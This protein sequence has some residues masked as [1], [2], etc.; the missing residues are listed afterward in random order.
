M[1]AT[2]LDEVQ[3]TGK[4]SPPTETVRGDNRAVVSR[5]DRP[6]IFDGSPG[7]N[8]SPEDLA[9]GAQDEEV[10]VF[11]ATPAQRRFWLLDQL[12][13]GGNPALNMPL[14][15]RLTGRLDRAALAESFQNILRRHEVL[16]TTF[17]FERG[18]LC[19]VIAPESTMH[20]DLVD[21]RDFPEPERARVPEH[22]ISEEARLPF[23][24]ARGP[25]FRA[26]LVR[27]APEEHL[28]LLTL[29]H[30][31][32]DGWT[33]GLILR[34]LGVFYTAAVTRRPAP[35]PEL[36]IQFAEFALWQHDALAAGKLDPQIA[37][38]REQLAGELSPLDLPVDRPR[39]ARRDNAPGAIRSRLL[40]AETVQA[41]KAV[42]VREGVSQFMIFLAGF[43]ALLHRCTGG[44]EDI[45]IGSPSANRDRV[46]VENLAGLFVNPLLLRTNLSGDPTF[47]ELLGRVRKTVLGAFSHAEVP[48][49][50]IIEVIQPRHLQVNFLYQTA[51]PQAA[52]LPD[53]TLTPLASASGG[54]LFE[55]TAAAVEE[56]GGT[57]LEIEYNTD[58]FEPETIDGFLAQYAALLAGAAA[59]IETAVSCLPLLDAKAAE[60]ALQGARAI[61]LAW[62]R[63]PTETVRWLERFCVRSPE[64]AAEVGQASPASTGGGLPDICRP[65]PGI[66]LL[67]LDQ[68]LHPV[69]P[70]ALG[71]IF[72]QGVPE[73][74][75]SLAY[76]EYVPD[77]RQPGAWLYQ[78]GDLGRPCSDG[79]IRWN[80]RAV[81]LRRVR[82]FRT[83]P[84]VTVA[85]LREHPHIR[86]AVVGW[87]GEGKPRL[88]AYLR[89]DGA[90]AALFAPSQLRAFLQERLSDEAVPVSFMVLERFPLNLEGRL[91]RS[92]LPVPPLALAQ[93]AEERHDAPYLTIHYQLIDLW[94]QLLGVPAVGIRDDFF[95]L[96]GNSLLAMRMLYRIEQIFGKAILPVALFKH[97][98]IEHLAN[99]MLKNEAGQR[100][101]AV[102]KINDQGAKTPIFYLHGDF[103]GG[104]F[105]SVKLSRHLGPEQPFYALPPVD[106]TD[107]STPATIEEMAA[108]QV[109]SIRGVRAHGPYVIGGF[110][111]GGLVAYEVARQLA[112]AGETVERLLIIDATLE[113]RRLKRLRRTAAALGRQRG[114]SANRQLYLFC[115]WHFLL[116]R[117]ERWRHMDFSRKAVVVRE[118]LKNRWYRLTHRAE[119]PVKAL[120]ADSILAGGERKA[121]DTDWFDPRWDVPLVYLWSAAGYQ[122]QP[123][124][125]PTTVLL[126]HDLFRGTE[127]RRLRDWKKYLGEL[128]VRELPGSHLACITEHVDALAET[129]VRCLEQPATP[130]EPRRPSQKE[131]VAT[132]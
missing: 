89:T 34:E 38:W 114:L 45:V 33:K 111:L 108:V 96:G 87:V 110:C 130:P 1:I 56:P 119:P 73:N 18:Q 13:P 62:W 125:G 4:A 131:V 51:F 35:L 76:S 105:Y 129:I 81:D 15:V 42:G 9:G 8:G 5:L 94:Q 71:Q 72:L 85:A 17:H 100:S 70:G 101:P 26:R 30:I 46:E 98:T 64:A 60:K 116:A 28:L 104:G 20:V 109:E 52:Q 90:P 24:L 78:T 128:D 123:Y 99:E 19:Q 67:V 55:W 61:R 106:M 10:F 11:P 82:G 2:L 126:S 91:E 93:T 59:D 84:E 79:V 36:A 3:L 88:A 14:A 68:C 66:S 21:V 39:H 7:L 57:R 54:A 122:P 132:A 97:A 107:P 22:L 50:T 86:D 63:L 117:L 49:E 75:G 47:R 23:D 118:R 92:A 16:R 95:A 74:D 27:V 29:H 53:L 12:V 115:R 48:F 112:E 43:T 80:G 6:A 32:A 65:R 44:Q 41:L 127:D 113:N 58:L 69:P 124:G 25:V 31:V 77:P 37:Y 103:H 83:D 102:V 121:T 120:T 40:P